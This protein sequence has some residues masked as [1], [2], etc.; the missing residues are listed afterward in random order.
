M[1]D[2]FDVG[3]NFEPIETAHDMNGYKS[4]WLTICQAL[5]G[6]ASNK[7]FHRIIKKA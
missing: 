3:N 2:N 1:K 7:R 5:L 4:L 6:E